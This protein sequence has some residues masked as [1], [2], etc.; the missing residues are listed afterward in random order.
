MLMMC[1][2]WLQLRRRMVVSKTGRVTVLT[3]LTFWG[4]LAVPN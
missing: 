4:R 3:E 1:P 2:E